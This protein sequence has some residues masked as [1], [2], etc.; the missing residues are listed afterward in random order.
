MRNRFVNFIRVFN[1]AILFFDKNQHNKCLEN[2]CNG[3]VFVTMHIHSAGSFCLARAN[4]NY[5]KT[6][7]AKN[8][9]G[10]RL[11][12]FWLWKDSVSNQH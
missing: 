5:T 12:F 1:R 7:L 9:E 11:L 3:F 6:A 8:H 10:D 2:V 4:F